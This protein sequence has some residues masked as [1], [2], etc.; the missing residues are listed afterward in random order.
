MIKVTARKHNGDDAYSWAVF[1]DDRVQ[2][3]GLH[4]SEVSYYKREVRNRLIQD[5]KKV[6]K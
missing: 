3:A 6:A 4:S 2:V 1:A 5:G